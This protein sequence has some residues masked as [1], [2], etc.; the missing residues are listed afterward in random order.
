[1]LCFHHSFIEIIIGWVSFPFFFSHPSR[2][3]YWCTC[4]EILTTTPKLCQS[5]NYLS[6]LLS[7]FF[8]SSRLVIYCFAGGEIAFPSLFC[9]SDPYHIKLRLARRE[10]HGH[11]ILAPDS[12]QL[13]RRRHP[14]TWWTSSPPL[15]YTVATTN[16]NQQP[17]TTSDNHHQPLTNTNNH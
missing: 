10:A 2:K 15:M 6:C 3:T 16:N 7:V 17:L 5:P 9:W 4:A 1:M 12:S 13:A 8:C 14:P 11:A